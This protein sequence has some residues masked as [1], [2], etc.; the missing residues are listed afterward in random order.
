MKV[1]CSMAYKIF[2]IWF[3]CH[4]FDQESLQLEIDN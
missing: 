3:I 2:V 1:D 4:C